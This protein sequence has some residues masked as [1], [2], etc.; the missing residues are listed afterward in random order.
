MKKLLALMI[1]MAFA[2]TLAATAA[3]AHPPEDGEGRRGKGG[4]PEKRMA[5]MQKKLGLSDEQFTQMR[6]IKANGGSREEMLAVMTEEQ[7]AEA[8]Q[9]RE[10]H[11]KIKKQRKQQPAPEGAETDEEL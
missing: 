8:K 1:G 11:R 6:E 2:A 7:R 9:L 4:D 10:Q 3:L 5:Q